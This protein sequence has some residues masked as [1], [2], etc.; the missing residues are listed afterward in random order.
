MMIRLICSISIKSKNTIH[1][2]IHYYLENKNP[3]QLKSDTK[4]LF[5]SKS[6]FRISYTSFSCIR[7]EEKEIEKL[8]GSRTPKASSLSAPW[9]TCAFRTVSSSVAPRALRTWCFLNRSSEVVSGVSSKLLAS[10]LQILM[11][12]LGQWQ[13]YP[14]LPAAASDF[15]AQTDFRDV[16]MWG[17]RRVMC[18]LENLCKLV[19]WKVLEICYA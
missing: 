14:S 15:K 6:S 4:C 10:V 9:A 7:R 12:V 13:P 2:R 11:C 8:F 16:K 1:R 17:E 5:C 3:S 18:F 19:L